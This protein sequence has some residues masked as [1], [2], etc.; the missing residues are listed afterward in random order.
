MVPSGLL[1]V[2]GCSESH[3]RFMILDKILVSSLQKACVVTT[4]ITAIT[5]VKRSDVKNA[6]MFYC[7]IHRNFSYK[8]KTQCNTTS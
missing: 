4:K 6:Y 2:Y 7:L 8:N 3:F 5:N 1:L